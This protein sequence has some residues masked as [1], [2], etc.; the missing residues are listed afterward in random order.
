MCQ[1][2]SDPLFRTPF[3]NLPEI[4]HYKEKR[5]DLNLK[6]ELFQESGQDK[7]LG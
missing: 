2:Y 5:P 1:L 3:L 4:S 7:N 6:I